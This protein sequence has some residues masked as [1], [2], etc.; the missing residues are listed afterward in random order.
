MKADKQKLDVSCFDSFTF[1][2]LAES[3]NSADEILLT[4]MTVFMSKAHIF[5]E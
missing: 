4:M 3:S 5:L 1:V 2:D